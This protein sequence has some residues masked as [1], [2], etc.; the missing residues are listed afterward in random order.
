MVFARRSIRLRD[1][2]YS[3]SGAYFV[4][5]CAHQRQCLFGNIQ[6]GT[7][8][9]NLLGQ[10]IQNCWNNIPIHFSKVELDAF[11]VMPNHIHAIVLL[12]DTEE[13]PLQQ[14]ASSSG[15]KQGSLGAV[16]GQFKSS[17]TRQ[18]KQDSGAFGPLWQRNYYE[19]I[20]RSETALNHIRTY[21]DINPAKWADDV[22]FVTS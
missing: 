18:F 1:Y 22:L 5:L 4:T 13:I 16:I 21:I 15:P 12:T 6:D 2:D 9:L 20:V 19:H 7:M 17:V 8:C 3:L 10:T 14:K 11:V